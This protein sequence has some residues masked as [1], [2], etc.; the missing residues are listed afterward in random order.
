M[1]ALKLAVGCTQIIWLLFWEDKLHISFLLVSTI[2]QR[3]PNRKDKARQIT[4][5]CAHNKVKKNSAM[6]PD[7]EFIHDCYIGPAQSIFF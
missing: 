2:P 6:P 5:D 4:N 1:H 7:I 3:E